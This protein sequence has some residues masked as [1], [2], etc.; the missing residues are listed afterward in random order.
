MSQIVPDE[1]ILGLLAANPGHGYQLLECFRD[2]AQL[3]E[4]WHLSTSQLYAVLKRL[5]KAGFITGQEIPSP[6]APARVQY[7][8][9]QSGRQ[10]LEG[11]LHEP[12]PSASV[13]RVRVEFLSRLYIAR[14]LNIPTQPLVARQKKACQQQL[15]ALI[16]QREAAAPGV[17]F[18]ALELVI[19]QLQAILGWI[20][21]C[22]LMPQPLQE[23]ET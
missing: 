7:R 22:E 19:A 14:L 23:D 1:T 8:I 6:D 16:A 5:E 10:Q 13:R 17:G 11:W 2:P 4:V 9:T 21:R 15:A 20:D 3:G 18:L 12:Q